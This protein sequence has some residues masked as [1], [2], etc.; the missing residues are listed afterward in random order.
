M[1][2]RGLLFKLSA[3]IA[4]I[5][6]VTGFVQMLRPELVLGIIG[7][8]TNPAP[9]HFFG[10]VGMF[11]VLFGGMLLHALLDAG[12]HRIVVLWSGLQK[13]GASGAVALG[14]W[15]GIFSTLA[16]G[17]AGFDLFSGAV[18]F[19]YMFGLPRGVRTDGATRAAATAK[20]VA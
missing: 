5:T 19:L 9:R 14:V 8:D 2:P 17:V 12:D 15:N 16:L 4:A 6:I 20:G 18:I 13:I 3:A 10:I 7:A 1:K 11:M